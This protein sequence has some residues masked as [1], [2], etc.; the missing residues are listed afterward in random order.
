V[1]VCRAGTRA[2]VGL[3][4]QEEKN[5]GGKEHARAFFSS[6]QGGGEDALGRAGKSACFPARERESEREKCLV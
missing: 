3:G 2:C 1:S 6:R 5:A 4:E